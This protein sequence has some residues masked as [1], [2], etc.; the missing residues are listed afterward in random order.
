MKDPKSAEFLVAHVPCKERRASI[1]GVEASVGS[2][3]C[4]LAFP[5]VLGLA[6]WA[7]AWLQVV[8][9]SRQALP[10]AFHQI[11]LCV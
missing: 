5:R 10:N 9:D 3:K 7:A 8:R 1:V 2:L 6:Q 11:F 4:W